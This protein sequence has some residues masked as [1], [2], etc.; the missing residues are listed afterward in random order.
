MVKVIHIAN[1]GTETAT[2]E[3]DDSVVEVLYSGIADMLREAATLQ[4]AERAAPC[5]V[6]LES[7][8]RVAPRFDLA[9]AGDRTTCTADAMKHADTQRSVEL[10]ND[11]CPFCEHTDEHEHQVRHIRRR[12][13]LDAFH[14]AIP[15]TYYPRQKP[16]HS[17]S[18][19]ER[20]H[21]TANTGPEQE[22]QLLISDPGHRPVTSPA[23]LHRSRCDGLGPVIIAR[24][25]HTSRI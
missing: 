10:V 5:D 3:L 8:N 4:N 14:G 6:S 16:R 25:A 17:K 23:T 24:S 9:S 18:S 20:L 19:D 13:L 2:V 22:L 15:L 12:D 11:G 21:A 1:I 7:G